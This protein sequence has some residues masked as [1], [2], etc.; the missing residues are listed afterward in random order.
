MSDTEPNWAALGGDTAEIDLGPR[1]VWHIE[2]PVIECVPALPGESWVDH[3]KRENAAINVLTLDELRSL[4][5]QSNAGGIYFLWK[6]SQLQYIGKS[7]QI[8][9]RLNSHYWALTFG[10]ASTSKRKQIPHDRATCLDV[11]SGW[12]RPPD[13][14]EK[15]RPLERAYIAHYQPPYNFLGPNPST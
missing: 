13:M 10:W 15:L 12:C 8:W 4:P 9:Q 6:G 1:V 2:V 11:V 3:M 7:G 5:E 14:D